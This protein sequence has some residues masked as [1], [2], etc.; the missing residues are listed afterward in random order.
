MLK[1]Y[2]RY[3]SNKLSTIFG[4]II[5]PIVFISIE[6]NNILF[7]T[8][9]SFNG[10]TL[11]LLADFRINSTLPI[12][13]KDII[14]GSY[15]FMIT[16]QTLLITYFSLIVYFSDKFLGVPEDGQF[17][18]NYYLAI[19]TMMSFYALI[20]YPLPLYLASKGKTHIFDV[21]NKIIYW[22]T[23]PVALL[24]V[25]FFL[26]ITII[27]NVNIYILTTISILV[28]IFNWTAGYLYS[29]KKIES[30]DF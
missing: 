29:A 16:I 9:M 23:M 25:L 26:G 8:W 3:F 20:V 5:I 17:R 11:H 24:I 10:I 30:I 12:S 13:R 27:E 2:K 19:F 18:L 6:N 22:I 14:K 7:L 28:S 15:L 21:N 1:I 4:F